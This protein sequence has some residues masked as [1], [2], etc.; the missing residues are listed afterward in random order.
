MPEL[1]IK[2]YSASQSEFLS[3]SDLLDFFEKHGSMRVSDLHLKV[4]QPPIYRVDGDLHKMKASPMDAA[5]LE[6]FCKCLLTEEGLTR[7]RTNR[8]VDGSFAA[9]KLNYRINCFYEADGMAVAI[10]ALPM[11]GPPVEQVGFPNSVWR[12]ILKSNH[13]LVLITG[14]TGAGKSTTIASLIERI[15]MERAVR[16]ITLED[17]IEYRLQSKVAM[18]SQR[19]V[20]RD[21]PS[22][23][24]G[25]RD[26]L[27]EDPDVIFVGEMRDRESAS[28]TLTAAETGHLVFSTLHTR[29]AR[30]SIT[31]IMD[32]FPAIQQDEVA[33]QISLGLSYVISQ[34]LIPRRDGHGRVLAMEVLNNTYAISNLIRVRKVEQIYT[35]L[36]TRTK[37]IPEERMTTL[38]LSLARLVKAGTIAPLEAEKFANDPNSFVDAMQRVQS[39]GGSDG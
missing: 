29:D 22:F 9:G 26:C 11:N 16:I 10:R 38:E 25:L 12:D 34:K 21:V 30:G 24:R 8:S 14:I 13:G 5:T 17:P 35:Y 6:G 4:G 33:N 3:I 7:L 39:D 23:E 27:R 15:A 31:R 1:N 32:M 19:E 18:I 20:G 28:W 36:Q 37:D 2:L